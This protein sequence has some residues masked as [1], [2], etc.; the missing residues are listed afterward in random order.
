MRQI[1]SLFVL[2]LVLSVSLQCWAQ[3]PTGEQEQVRVKADA[4]TYEEQSNTV[5]AT[6]NVVVTKGETTVSADAV[7]V[8]RAT[9]E[10]TARGNVVV[11]DPQGEI[12][13]DT[14]RLEMENET[15]ELTN[16]T[17]RLPRNQYILTGKTLQKSYG[18]SYHIEN[19][20]FTT[21][22]CNDFRKA[23]WSI[24]GKTVD[25]TLRGKGEVYGGVFRVRDVPLL[26]LPYAVVPLNKERQ[27][28]FLFPDYGF[29]SKRGFV[30]QQPFYW[31]ISK[32]QDMTLTTDLETSA[33]IGLWGEYR[34]AP[35]ERTEG[36]L[37][38]SYFN[39]Q[40][41]GP[42]TTS[43]PV[44]RWSLTGTHRQSLRDDLRL[45]S[46]L[47]FVGDDTFL[48]DINHHALDLP[49]AEDFSG[50]D[51]RSRRFTDSHVGGVKTWANA[52][53]RTEASYY[54]DLQQDQDSAFQVLPRI[55]FQGQQR[56]W[57]D[58]LE[59]GIAVEGV[60]FYRNQGYAGQ[61]LDLAP[62]V[63]LPFHFGDYAFGSL[64]AV[65]RETAYHLTSEALG[66]PP[67]PQPDRLHGDSTRE[68]VQLNAQIGTRLSRVFDVGWGRLL[69]L[70]HVVEPEIAYLYVPLVGQ[71]DL[72]LYDSLDRINKRNLFV[73]GV[74][75]QL[76]GKFATTPVTDGSGQSEPQTEVRELA[77]LSVTHAYDP[78]RR[79][80]KDENHFSDVD[81][82]ARLTPLPYTTFT[83]DSTYD[84]GGGGV[85]AMRAGAFLRD[86][87]PLPPTSP[88][89]QHLQ[90]ST[91]VGVSYRFTSDSLV[92]QFDPSSDVIPPD[93]IDANIIF[94]LNEKFTGAYSGRYDL[95]T[96]SFIGNRYFVR[97]FSP[98]HCWFVDFGGIDK[99][100]P[101][102]FEF[103]F[104]FTL[105]GLSSSGRP[106]F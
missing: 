67:L 59:T 82:N 87:R 104:M 94:R 54:Q 86:P 55:Q 45:Y 49:S 65:G 75:N 42:A 2:L 25:V 23:D 101:H 90:R 85:I 91:T 11:K 89:L 99:V 39:E 70:Q 71:E 37:A 15:G 68:T 105:V 5:T 81:V 34:Y 14:L 102:E 26:Y 48:R 53:L 63:A 96:S 21:C 62:S 43:A 47:F 18:Q 24:S 106:M 73:Y 66:Q 98:Q 77:R 97:Y 36:Q 20:A 61:R 7:G 83:L 27:S 22:Q 92:K 38:A 6:G 12:N 44:N 30:W 29:S 4:L 3:T 72:P 103:R 52:L 50:S 31:A 56:V 100:N 51:L 88:L 16:G 78:T 28:G 40:I 74:S 93:E 19:G 58:R 33:R 69:K 84:M 80:S 41:G 79:L 17:V 1:S 35:N 9:N 13:A 46:D 76:L 32:S 10:V 64:R 95:H 8:N 60:N 57:H